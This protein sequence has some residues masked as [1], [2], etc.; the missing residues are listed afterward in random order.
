MVDVQPKAVRSKNMRAIRSINTRPEVYVRR[1]LHALG[2]RFRIHPTNLPAKVDIYLPKY[3]AVIWVNGCFWHGH[4]C[5]LF[6]QPQTNAQFWDDKISA[7]RIRDS[8]K[9][10][11]IGKLGLK[12]LT[13]WECAL[14]GKT[15]LCE[16]ELSE[17]LEEWL[18]AIQGDAQIDFRGLSKL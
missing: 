8:R 7:N 12:Q 4:N 16:S 9:S 15:R 1:L 14:K 13:I 2:F 10:C 5:H 11:S 6:K 3:N 17:R 18:L